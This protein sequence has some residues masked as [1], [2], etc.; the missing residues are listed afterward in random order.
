MTENWNL[1]EILRRKLQERRDMVN[2]GSSITGIGIADG[3]VYRVDQAGGTADGRWITLARELATLLPDNPVACI[4]LVRMVTS[5]GLKEAK[6]L[7]DLFLRDG[8]AALALELGRNGFWHFKRCPHCLHTSWE[9]A[10]AIPPDRG[11][12]DD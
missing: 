1:G 2:I 10:S 8:E 7:C 6:D 9:R 12:S 11:V 4:K 5:Y 3:R